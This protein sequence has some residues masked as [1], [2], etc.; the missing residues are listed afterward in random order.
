MEW[1]IWKQ[2]Q[3]IITLYDN[4]QPIKTNYYRI[5]R[6][7]EPNLWQTITI[8]IKTPKN[9]DKLGIKFWNAESEKQLQIDDLKVYFAEY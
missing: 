4:E 7:I 2:T 6:I 3:W 9:Y 1:E 5:Y 8:D